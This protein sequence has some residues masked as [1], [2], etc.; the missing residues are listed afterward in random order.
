MSTSVPELG[1]LAPPSVV[2]PLD[3]EAILDAHRADLIA[4]YPAAADVIHLESE[5]LAKLLEAHAYREMLFRARVNDAA[6]AHLLAFATG[7]DID[8]LAA[9][10]GVVRMP[11]ESDERLRTRLQLR[12]AALGA[13]GTK[14]HYELHAM[15]ASTMVRSAAASQPQ[16][17]HV[18]VM[19]W[20]A[21]Q[22]QGDYVRQQVDNALNQ[23]NAR[24]LGISLTV[25][26]AV[27]RPIH[28]TARITRTARAPA[29]LMAQLADRLTA[30]FNSLSTLQGSIARSWLTTVLHVD[31]VHAVDWPDAGTPQQLTPIAVGEYPTLGAVKL[32]DAGAVQ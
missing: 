9:L 22:A 19:L 13:Q 18:L 20:V 26:V 15:N 4:R 10:F 6:R 25:A 24:M 11:G 8:H 1:K 30:A 2:E 29:N 32:I 5:P 23:D 31:G 12:I 14:E 3:F 16:P 17:G 28:I 21:D 7:T 27:P